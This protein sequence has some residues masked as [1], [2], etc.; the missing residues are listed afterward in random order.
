MRKLMLAITVQAPFLAVW[1]AFG[2]FKVISFTKDVVQ[3]TWNVV[4]KGKRT[5]P[6]PDSPTHRLL[7]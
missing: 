1:G 3:L 2:V 4:S 5:T 7:P 6:Q